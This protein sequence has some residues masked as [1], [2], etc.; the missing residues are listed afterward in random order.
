MDEKICKTDAQW[1]SDLNPEQY[2]VCRC[3]ATEP[4]FSGKYWD[5]HETGT[6]QCAACGADLFDSAA[7]FATAIGTPLIGIVLIHQGWR[8]SFAMTGVAS[9]VFFVAF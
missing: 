8:F 1:R 2:A 4:P 5:H 9:F 7:K 6:Y 3:S